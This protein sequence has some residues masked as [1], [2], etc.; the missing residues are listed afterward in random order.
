[1]G[2]RR[3]ITNQLALEYRRGTRAEN[4]AI[5]DQLVK[6]TGWHRDHARARLR[7]VGEVRVT[8]ARTPR[9]PVY[10]SRVIS[11]LELCWRIA[12]APAASAWL[13]CSRSP[14]S[15]VTFALGRVEACS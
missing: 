7:T 11:A 9:R 15:P 1:M 12:R 10:S 6:L 14:S 3:A 5:L 8:Q 13:P 2:E 4:G